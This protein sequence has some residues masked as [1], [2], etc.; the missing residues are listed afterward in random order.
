[1][2]E[3]EVLNEVP[4]TSRLYLIGLYEDRASNKWKWFFQDDLAPVVGYCAMRMVGGGKHTYKFLAVR[5]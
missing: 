2:T 5:C 1:M 4:V 3:L